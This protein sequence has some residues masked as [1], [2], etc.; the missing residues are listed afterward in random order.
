MGLPY[1]IVEKRPTLCSYHFEG[2]YFLTSELP[3]SITY[4][5]RLAS[6]ERWGGKNSLFVIFKGTASK[7]ESLLQIPGSPRILGNTHESLERDFIFLQ[8]K[9]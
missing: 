5:S 1:C 9:R 2:W 3:S 8:T 4:S 6:E 7:S